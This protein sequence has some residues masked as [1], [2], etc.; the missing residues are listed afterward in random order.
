MSRKCYSLIWQGWEHAQH[1][2]MG[3]KSLAS[4]MLKGQGQQGHQCLLREPEQYQ[5]Q[6]H[7]YTHTPFH[8]MTHCHSVCLSWPTTYPF[9]CQKSKC[10]FTPL[11]LFWTHLS[12]KPSFYLPFFLH[13]L[14]L[15]ASCKEW[16]DEVL[17]W[18]QT[19]VQWGSLWNKYMRT[20]CLKCL[21]C[22]TLKWISPLKLKKLPSL[23]V[24]CF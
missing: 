2:P 21:I 3:S 7:A 9:K 18:I 8:Q 20:A 12:R 4:N 10:G 6:A 17:T 16:K 23:A 13:F 22:S 1:L 19:S 14:L 15:I 11:E 5:H 24:L